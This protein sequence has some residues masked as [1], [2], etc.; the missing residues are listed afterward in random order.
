MEPGNQGTPITDLHP[1]IDTEDDGWKIDLDAEVE[2]QLAE[3]ERIRQEEQRSR[4]QVM[5]GADYYN[6]NLDA[7]Q[8]AIQTR[9]Q[10]LG[11]PYMYRVPETGEYVDL[12]QDVW[13]DENGAPLSDEERPNLSA[14]YQEPPRVIAEEPALDWQ[15]PTF[16]TRSMARAAREKEAQGVLLELPYTGGFARVRQLEMADKAALAWVPQNL[17]DKLAKVMALVNDPNAGGKVVSGTEAFNRILKQA[18]D[19]EELANVFCI[20]G[21]MEPKLVRDDE[22]PGDDE[23]TMNVSDLHINERVGYLNNSIAA[24]RDIRI[25]D[26]FR[27]KPVLAASHQQGNQKAAKA[28]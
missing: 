25:L 9:L 7:R 13:L 12:N 21:F 28:K 5:A 1:E 23:N 14:D 15:N 3:Q 11:K 20:R 18:E 24:G 10:E 27:G 16:V 4:F 2:A 22:D 17:R 26:P 8:L 6:V 19:L